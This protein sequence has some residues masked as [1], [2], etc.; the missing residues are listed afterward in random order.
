MTYLS[1]ERKTLEYWNGSPRREGTVNS[2]G[3]QTM[4]RTAPT[5]TRPSLWHEFVLELPGN[6]QQRH[7]V[8]QRNVEHICT[9]LST[10]SNSIQILNSQKGCILSSGI[11]ASLQR[12]M[13]KQSISFTSAIPDA[14]FCHKQLRS[15]CRIVLNM[16]MLQLQYYLRGYTTLWDVKACALS[17]KADHYISASLSLISHLA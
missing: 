2:A 10:F 3:K 8:Q 5:Y 14:P 1:T 7:Q 16:E 4:L 15:I 6:N 12:G 9:Q 11:L 17:Y 13:C